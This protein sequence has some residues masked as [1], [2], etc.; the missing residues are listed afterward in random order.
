MIEDDLAT[1]VSLNAMMFIVEMRSG[2]RANAEIADDYVI[3][4]DA[5]LVIFKADTSAWSRLARDCHIGFINIQDF[6]ISANPTWTP[7]LTET[8]RDASIRFLHL[9]VCQRIVPVRVCQCTSCFPDCNHP[10]PVSPAR[11]QC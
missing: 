3:R 6:I 8:L 11:G 5:E 7:N 2:A 10:D 4:V 9:V 1:T